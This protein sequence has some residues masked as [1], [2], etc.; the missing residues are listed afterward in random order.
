M[1]VLGEATYNNNT[2]IARPSFYS[3]HVTFVHHF[4]TV[5]KP[6]PL[7]KERRRRELGKWFLLFC[8]QPHCLFCTE[9]RPHTCMHMCTHST[10]LC[11]S[12]PTIYKA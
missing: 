12:L 1:W 8:L 5:I 4:L 10:H 6:W 3:L 11:T 9:Q 2:A 7:R